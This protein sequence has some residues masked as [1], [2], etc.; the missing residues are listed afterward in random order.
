[1]AFNFTRYDRQ[2]TILNGDAKYHK[3]FTARNVNFIT[4]F[5]TPQLKWPTK[6][7]LQALTVEKEIWKVGTRFFKLAH[8]YYEDPSFWWV[9]AWF[10][11]KPLEADFENGDTVMIPTPLNRILSFYG[12]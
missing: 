2:S 8:K 6:E 10:N 3:Q 9:I 4:H 5:S 1:M 11:Q 7:E 12:F